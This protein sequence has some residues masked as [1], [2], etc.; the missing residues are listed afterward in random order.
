MGT[1]PGTGG[2]ARALTG[3]RQSAPQGHTGAA[4]PMPC[5]QRTPCRGRSLCSFRTH[6]GA[7]VQN[8]QPARTRSPR[9]RPTD[10]GVAAC[11]GTPHAL[12]SAATYTQPSVSHTGAACRQ[13]W[14]P[15]DNRRGGLGWAGGSCRSRHRG[16]LTP[17]HWPHP[18]AAG[19][20]LQSLGHVPS[21]PH[22]DIATHSPQCP[23][24]CMS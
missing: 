12:G 17:P 1:S 11:C 2:L 23:Q 3:G 21:H 24:T 22:V 16:G 20:G 6:R 10:R 9:L 8:S 15:P 14:D 5:L 19:L 13:R 4:L 7:S 18:C